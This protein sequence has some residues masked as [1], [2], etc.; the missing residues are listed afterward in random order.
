MPFAVAL[1][2]LVVGSILF[3]ILSP[4]TFTPLSSNWGMVDFTVDVT[5]YVTAII[6]VA[7][8]LFVAAAIL[9]Y[10]HREGVASKARY[11]PENKRLEVWLTGLTAVGVAAMLTPGLLVWAR[12]VEVPE[13]AHVVEAVG[14]QWHWTYRYPGA[15]GKLGHV[16]AERIG[17]DNP[18]GIDPEDPHGQDDVV[19]LH[20]EAH[21]P[22]DRPV[23][24]LLRSKDVLHNFTVAQFR[25]KMDLVPGMDTFMW[26][27]PTEA[28]RFEVLCE[29]LC[30][31][32]HHTMRGAVVVED[33]A[34]FESWLDAQPTFAELA[35]RPAGDPTVGAAQYAVCAACHGQQGEGLEAMNAP[36]LAG[37][38]A[39][40]LR[41][42]IRAFQQGLRG[43]HADDTYGQQMLA[44][45]RTLPDETAIANVVA[46]IGTLP[47]EPSPQ[48]ITGD[49]AR[50]ERIAQVC[51]Y[52]HGRDG[53]GVQATNA[54]RYAGMD[55]WYLAR[56]L[57]NFRA[58]VRGTHPQDFYGMQMGFMGRILKDE[59]AINDVVA[60]INTLDAAPSA[61]V[62]DASQ[63]NGTGN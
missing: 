2:L 49:A 22:I 39:W 48:T 9:K 41:E 3:H 63:G 10:R 4:W 45:A 27:E 32:A 25:V 13:E 30:G 43:T 37:Q 17:P 40:Y 60:Y 53:M 52:C 54:P 34:D 15:D 18:L 11:E 12:F 35:A 57:A 56:Q 46:H 38:D 47:D 44:M 31:V 62:A 20:P 50:G 55:D 8:N 42:E 59:Q 21:L 58:G 5:L 29:E 7:V 28:G 51:G 19:V 24:F 33:G 6:F 1:I 36:K 61:E 14:Q 26:L 16:D 23:K